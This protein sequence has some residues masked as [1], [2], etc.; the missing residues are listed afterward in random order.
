MCTAYRRDVK[1]ARTPEDATGYVAGGGG[2][3]KGG[4]GGRAVLDEKKMVAGKPS[5]RRGPLR[6]VE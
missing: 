1:D 4:G 6:P 2:G 5:P 3:H